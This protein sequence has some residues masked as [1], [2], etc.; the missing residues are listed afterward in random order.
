MN[1]LALK[2]IAIIT[3]L[4]DH[5]TAVL[6]SYET[7]PNLY[8]LGRTI[9][10]LAFPIFCFLLVEGLLHTKDVRKYLLRLALFAILSEVPFD[11]A[12]F[13]SNYYLQHQN[14]FFTLL[15]GLSVIFIMR[16][17]EAARNAE[18]T[19]YPFQVFSIILEVIIVFTGCVAAYLLKTDYSVFGVLQIVFFYVFRK[20]KIILLLFVIF[21]NQMLGVV[22]GLPASIEDIVN[23]LMQVVTSI[24]IQSFA[25]FAMILIFT[26]HGERGPKLNKYIFYAFYPVH[27]TILY[28]INTL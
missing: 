8:L 19:T 3:M 17:L 28:L 22:F 14:I 10:R 26:Y 21:V 23:I 15:I 1:G 5:T 7:S 4:I 6:V 12:F 18:E 13:H 25:T 2:L 24:S 27:L 20:K 11:L 9:G 16:K